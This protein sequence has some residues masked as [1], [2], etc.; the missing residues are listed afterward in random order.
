MTKQIL[1]VNWNEIVLFQQNEKDFISL[2]DIAKRKNSEFPADVIKNWLRNKFT[3]EFIWTWEKINNIDFKLVEFD[4][5]KSEAWSNA[6]VMTP[7]KWI[8]STNAIWIVSK[9]WKYGWTFAHKDI[10]LEFASWISPEFKLYIIKEF[11]RLKEEEKRRELSGWDIK[12][13]IASVNYKI[14]TDSIKLNLIPTISEFEQ[15]YAYANEADLI[16]L[17]IFWKTAKMWEEEN[18]ELAKKWNMRDYAD[19]I[20]L[21]ILSNLESFNADYL[22]QWLT[23]KE[24]FEKLSKIAQTQKQSLLSD[25]KL[26]NFKKITN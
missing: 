9:S 15:K 1:K 21:I 18:P 19:I 24:R 8:E 11:Q 26:I 23:R 12:R 17:I 13:S 20:E 25:K 22:E 3:L 4:Q 5:F 10:A 16:N 6:F 2:T 7:K 14:Q